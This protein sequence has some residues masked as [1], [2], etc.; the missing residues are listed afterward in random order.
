MT[1]GYKAADQEDCGSEGPATV[2]E[3][4]QIIDRKVEVENMVMYH[5][6]GP[7]SKLYATFN[8]GI[9]YQFLNHDNQ[10]RLHGGDRDREHLDERARGGEEEP[11]INTGVFTVPHG[12]S[13][14][15]ASCSVNSV[16]V[17]RPGRELCVL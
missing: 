2:D 8:N 5:R 14:V 13:G 11:D 3:L 12:L 16:D 17:T 9:C 15:W 4:K 7:G 6:L 1:E 10:V